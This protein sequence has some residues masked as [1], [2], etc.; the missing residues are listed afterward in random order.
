MKN[1]RMWAI[2]PSRNIYILDA[3]IQDNYPQSK[4]DNF[5]QSHKTDFIISHTRKDDT[6]LQQVTGYYYEVSVTISEGYV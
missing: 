5:V 3:C 4:I 1:L 2:L 6:I